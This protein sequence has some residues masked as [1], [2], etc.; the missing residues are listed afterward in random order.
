[1]LEIEDDTIGGGYGIT[2]RIAM[3]KGDINDP[4]LANAGQTHIIF[5]MLHA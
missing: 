3:Y 4:M 5:E 1:M 2:P